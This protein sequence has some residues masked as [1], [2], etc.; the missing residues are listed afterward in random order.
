MTSL[1]AAMRALPRE[2]TSFVG[3]FSGPKVDSARNKAF[4]VWLE[5]TDATHFLFVDTDMVIPRD[6]IPRL[7]SH[8]KD[9]VGGLCFAGGPNSVVK[10]TLHVIQENDEGHPT[11]ELLWDYP[12]NSLVQVDGTG[13]ACMMVKREV[14]EKVWEARGRDHRLPWFAHGMHNGV[15]IGED[16]AFCLTA[17][18]CGYEVWVDTGLEVPHVKPVF[19]GQREYVLSLSQ[20]S[21]PYYTDRESVP[22]YQDMTNGNSS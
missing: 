18:K 11:L 22:I 8:D 17:G 9:I 15:E 13:A 3:I 20:E 21:H 2:R 1:I 5:E 4:K 16:I 19:M 10:P 12:P 7:L 14:A 6:T